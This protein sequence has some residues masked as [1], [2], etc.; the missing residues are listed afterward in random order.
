MIVTQTPLRVSFF[1]GGTDFAGFYRESGGCVLSTAIDKYIF[2]VVKR[3]FDEQIRLGYTR[4]EMVNSVDELQHELAREALRMTGVTRQIELGTLGDIPAAGSGLGSSSTVTVGMLGALY[5]YLNEHQPAETLARKA[6][7]IE[8]DRLRKPIGKQD[9]YIAA[10]GGLR[11]IRFLPDETVAIE[12]VE[13]TD[14]VRARLELNLM[15]FY[16]DRTRLSETVLRELNGNVSG[17]AGVLRALRKMALEGRRL[18]EAGLLDDFGRL[19]HEGWELK[20]RM[21]TRITSGEIDG[22]YAAARAAGALG[23]KICG[24]GGG[25]FMLLYCPIESQDEVRRALCGRRELPFRL[26]P[27]GSKV[28]LN[29]RR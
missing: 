27:D 14:R 19:L 13:L 18:L 23:G 21:A 7:E 17:Q 11:F 20:K 22:M 24:A 3:R 10:Y 5:A 25:G 26:E 12:T 9:Q 16:T 8:I 4:T 2:V 6:C 28:I 29:Y 1:G 15:L